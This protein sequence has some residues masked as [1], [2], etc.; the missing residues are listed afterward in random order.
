M[1]R[2]FKAYLEGLQSF[3]RFWISRVYMQKGDTVAEVFQS[4]LRF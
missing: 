2:G 4:F 3:L 1:W